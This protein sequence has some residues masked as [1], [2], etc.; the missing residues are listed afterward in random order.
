MDELRERS[1]PL[2]LVALNEF[3][4][5]FAVLQKSEVLSLFFDDNLDENIV[6]LIDVT[7]GEPIAIETLVKSG[8]AIRVNTL[9]AILDRDYYLKQ[10]ERALAL[11][12]ANPQMI[13]YKGDASISL[14]G[15]MADKGVAKIRKKGAALFYGKGSEKG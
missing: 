11:H 13:F 2:Y 15:M 12:C 8:Q 10:V 7:T 14:I 3:E 4:E 9:E 5:A 6:S 1:H